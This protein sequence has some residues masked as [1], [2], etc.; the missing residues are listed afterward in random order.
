[1]DTIIIILTVHFIRVN[2]GQS[3]INIVLKHLIAVLVTSVLLNLPKFFETSA[4][5]GERMVFSTS[6]GG[7]EEEMETW[8]KLSVTWLRMNTTYIH[9]SSFIR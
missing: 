6:C 4:S 3:N 7:E 2:T 5:W 9:L 1:M 8:V